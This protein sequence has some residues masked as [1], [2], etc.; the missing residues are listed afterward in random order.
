MSWLWGLVLA[1]GVAAVAYRL[2]LLTLSGALSAVFVG[3][4]VFGM[5]GVLASVP[6]I[7]FFFTSSLLPRL[8]GRPHKTERRTAVQVLANGLAPTLCCWG[9]WLLPEHAPAFWLGYAASLATAAADTWATEFGMRF[10][11]GARMITTG[12]PIPKGESGGVS[13]AGTL[14]GFGGAVAIALLCA[15]LLNG[16][17]AIGVAA[18][19]GVLGMLLDSL[20]GATVQARF[21]CPVCQSIGEKRTCCDTLTLPHRGVSWMDNNAVNFFSTISSAFLGIGAFFLIH[22]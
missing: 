18:C 1:G 22:L 21:Q 20:L 15:P 5:G 8:L 11:K 4:S 7:A 3:V 6:M 13:F 9:V 14:G 16:V 17:T 19:V 10:G 12:K 2:R